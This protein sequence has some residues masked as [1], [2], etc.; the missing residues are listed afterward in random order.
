M[1]AKSHDRVVVKII[2]PSKLTPDA[3]SALNGKH[4]RVLAE[5]RSMHVAPQSQ[6]LLVELDQPIPWLSEANQTKRFWLRR[7]DLRIL[8][9]EK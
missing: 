1:V 2:N 4:G 8:K 7:C 9:G 5:Q 3:R 6:E